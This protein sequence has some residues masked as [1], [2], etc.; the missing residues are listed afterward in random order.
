MASDYTARDGKVF[1]RGIFHTEPECVRLLATFRLS[2]SAG[3][4]F[5]PF[6]KDLAAQ[7]EAAMADAAWQQHQTEAA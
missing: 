5:S 2:E 7:L 3:D 6:A 4:W 1:I